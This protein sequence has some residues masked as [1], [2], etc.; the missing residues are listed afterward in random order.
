MVHYMLK[1]RVLLA[2]CGMLWFSA[3]EASP[4][5]QP[6]NVS[7]FEGSL[8]QAL[9]AAKKAQKPVFVYFSAHWCLPCVALKTQLF[10]DPAFESLMRDRYIPFYMDFDAP[11]SQ[12][13][14]QKFGIDFIPQIVV[15]SPDGKELM[16]P[17]TVAGPQ[18]VI[19]TLKGGASL[20]RPLESI[21]E[22]AAAG[23]SVA[24]D[25]SEWKL[26]VE[27]VTT[28]PTP[29]LKNSDD[30]IK[31]YLAFYKAIP[32]EK[33][34]LRRK[35]L[36]VYL[37]AQEAK[38][39]SAAREARELNKDFETLFGD[40]EKSGFPEISLELIDL[41]VTK[42]EERKKYQE[43]LV[44][45]LSRWRS[46]SR[47]NSL[48]EILK[49]IDS[50]DPLLILVRDKKTT[51]TSAQLS[52]FLK[53]ME[54]EA[55]L[56]EQL[57]PSER[58]VAG[59]SIALQLLAA[60]QFDRA[61]A[62]AQ[63]EIAR[64]SDHKEKFLIARS[65]IARERGDKTAGKALFL[66]AYSV[67]QGRSSKLFYG[68]QLLGSGHELDMQPA[69]MIAIFERI[70]SD[71]FK[72]DDSVEGWDSGYFGALLGGAATPNDKIKIDWAPVRSRIEKAAC[73]GQP[74]CIAIARALGVSTTLPKMIVKQVVNMS[75]ALYDK[76]HL[77]IYFENKDGWHTY[78]KKADQITLPM[79]ISTHKG[80]QVISADAIERWPA[81]IEF[82][83]ID[84]EKA[85][86]Y[87]GRYGFFITNS[88][89]I[90][91]AL[92]STD[93]LR[94]EVKW[95]A[96]K[97]IC[98]P[99]TS[100]M[101]A[102]LASDGTLTT[103]P[104]GFAVAKAEADA[105]FKGA[106]SDP[107]PPAESEGLLGLLVILALA[108]LGGFILNFMPC[109]LPVISIKLFSL[110]KHSG[111]SR[112]TVTKHS[113]A[114]TAGILVSFVALAAGVI[115]LKISGAS[116]GWGFQLQS[117]LFIAVMVIVV[118][119]MMLSFFGL[120]EF[121]A[122][123]MNFLVGKLDKAERSQQISATAGSFGNGLLATL[124]AT[125][126]SAPFLGTALAFAF[127]ASPPMIVLIF[128]FVG[129]GLAAPFLLIA[130]FPSVLRFL[131]RPGAWME[132]F[133]RFLGMLLG[134]TLVWLIDVYTSLSVGPDRA[135]WLSLTLLFTFFAIY[136][137]Q[138]VTRSFI[139]RALLLALFVG[140]LVPLVKSF[141]ETEQ[142]AL[143]NWQKWSPEAQAQAVAEGK[144]VFVD[145]TAEWCITC[146][147][148][149]KLFL[150]TAAF[151]ELVKKEGVVVMKA[152]F[153]RSDK[154]IADFLQAHGKPG[155]PAYFV[156]SPSKGL[157]DLGTMLTR[158]ILVD[159]L[160]G[161]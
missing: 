106:S 67:A 75:L 113:L 73:R 55:S 22:D 61:E 2:L 1:R 97:D 87:G 84:K 96:C 35:L 29:L 81:T 77:G 82:V 148:N 98:I 16:R 94:V 145:F 40:L 117:P 102:R 99:G 142:S 36:L 32:V 93:G 111:E 38:N 3:T 105:W 58:D 107:N 62:I 132:K 129:I 143:L 56:L 48:L 151:A 30:A 112:S 138:H 18:I 17:S 14:F 28:N 90:Q 83:G 154:V 95:L 141:N 104:L 124:L 37:S 9:D 27:R 31:A 54:H 123:G 5:K 26:L 45:A 64:G 149:E 70:F 150:D 136:G 147:Y 7:W 110:V 41:M 144:T 50:W 25:D 109:V 126:C 24:L 92:Q 23:K 86:G 12:G 103:D 6:G 39:S 137:W 79:A 153:T 49:R 159:A 46:E 125:P 122:L 78:A 115:V 131:P 59:R 19:D 146:K 11:G 4:Y 52:E 121:K 34:E 114:Y 71:Y 72:G 139:G 100:T 8:E 57:T 74:N 80:S 127:L 108:L 60:K 119:I 161:H 68:A 66:E 140:S 44:A 63:A 133:R 10:P 15:V 33:A 152:D 155:V 53:S 69:E 120:F 88:Q 89:T 42:P 85:T 20:K 43:R 21:A 118:F 116:V 47:D 13:W 101:T 76:N 65:N 160:T 128:I 130:A 158:G 91:E 134:I 156:Q 157:I 51:F 135:F